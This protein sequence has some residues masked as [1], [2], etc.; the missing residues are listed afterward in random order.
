MSDDNEEV[1]RLRA[2]VAGLKGELKGLV[3]ELAGMKKEFG[4]S[5]TTYKITAAQPSLCLLTPPSTCFHAHTLARRRNA[6]PFN[7]PRHG[8]RRSD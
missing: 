8:L 2:E 1:V 6:L 4:E 5:P 7:G 3:G